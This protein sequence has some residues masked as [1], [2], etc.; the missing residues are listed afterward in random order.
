VVLLLSANCILPTISCAQKIAGGDSHSLAVCSDST[1]RAWG[2]NNIGQLGNGNSTDSDVPVEVS[3]ITG[4]AAI[5]GG[6]WYSLA[7]KNDG[8]V[9]AWGYNN[10]GQLG[11]GSN[12]IAMFQCR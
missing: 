5:G 4:I 1:A 6:H 8:T 12:T 9:S 2:R 10:H 3:A 11:N 7:L